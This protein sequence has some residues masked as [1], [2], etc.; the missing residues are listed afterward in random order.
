MFLV[1][2]LEANWGEV[3]W[4]AKLKISYSSYFSALLF[5][6]TG[7][8][9]S[10][11]LRGTRQS[12]NAIKGLCPYQWRSQV[13]QSILSVQNRE[14]DGLVV[15]DEITWRHHTLRCDR[16]CLSPSRICYTPVSIYSG[17]L[18]CFLS[19]QHLRI[20]P[21]VIYFKYCLY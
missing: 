12:I 15:A 4:V 1:N 7:I 14:A 5:I 16:R 8:R 9:T 10:T 20:Y 6:D 21:I 18:L 19:I 17:H 13:T 3:R 11:A 2:N